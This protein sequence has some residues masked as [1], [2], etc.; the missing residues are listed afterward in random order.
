MITL[1]HRRKTRSSRFII[2]LEELDAPD[3]ANPHPHGKVPAISDDG[4]IVFESPAI[5]LY[6]TDRCEEPPRATRR[7]AVQRRGRNLRH[8][9]RHVRAEPHDAEVHGDRRV[10]TT[11]CRAAGLCARADAGER[12]TS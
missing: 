5:A 12:L 1:F 3:A 6:L 11:D 4:V 7:R 2:L 10:R 9:V 8:D